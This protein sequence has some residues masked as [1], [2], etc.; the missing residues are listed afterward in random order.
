MA[1]DPWRIVPPALVETSLPK[2]MVGSNG[3]KFSAWKNTCGPLKQ[4]VAAKAVFI[5]GRFNFPQ[6]I[7]DAIKESRAKTPR[8]YFTVGPLILV[9]SLR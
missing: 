6:A 1:L 5:E 4:T 2:S 8:L 9:L 3:F 7:V